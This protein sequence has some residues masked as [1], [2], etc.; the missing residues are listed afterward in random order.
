MN[1]L[2]CNTENCNEVVVCDD[3]VVGVTCGTCCTLVGL[4]CNEL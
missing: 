2:N 4:E 1:E 3:D